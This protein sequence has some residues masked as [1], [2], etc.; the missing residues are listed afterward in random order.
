MKDLDNL[1]IPKPVEIELS[2][3]YDFS[4]STFGYTRV[5]DFQR[6]QNINTLGEVP[7]SSWFTNRMGRKVM[8][9][10]ELVKGPNTKEGPAP[11]TWTVTKAK[12]Q[13][14][15]PGFTIKDERGDTY[16]IKFDPKKNPQLATSAEVICTKFFYAFGYNVPENYLT[17]LNPEDLQILEDARITD[18]EGTKRKFTRDDLENI[19]R[20]IPRLPDGRIQV[21]ASLLLPGEPIGPF[22]YW[23]TR[24]DDPNDI[25]PHQHRREL[26]GL[27]LFSA[28]LNH[29]DSR[30]INS[31]DM[32]VTEGDSGYVRHNLIDFGSTL[33]SGSIQVQSHRA[34]NE[35][36]IEGGPTVKSAVTFG[37]WDRPWRHYKYPDYPSIGRFESKNFRPELW[38]PE[39]PNPAFDRLQNEDAFWAVRI[40][41][42]FSDEMVRAVVKTGQ[43]ADPQAEDYLVNTLLERRDKIIHYYLGQVSSLDE[44]SFAADGTIQFVNLAEKA[45]VAQQDRYEY[46]WHTFDNEKETAEPIEAETTSASA[47]PIPKNDAPFLMLRINNLRAANA[48]WKKTVHVYISNAPSPSVIGI[49]RD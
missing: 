39:Y 7:D 41:L 44:F 2:Q 29:D 45:G 4:A 5:K 10:D 40:L 8:S 26:R 1:A 18:E 9:V 38:R 19:L 35:Y 37:L 49:E 24:S 48:N 15:T 30:S 23:G 34:G 36:M 32:Y 21:I 47:I 12:T 27:R 42:R 43:I 31:L 20:K 13:G 14:I 6:A 11:G 46:Q 28:W 17:I 16:F 25:F 22:Q 3:V 33:G